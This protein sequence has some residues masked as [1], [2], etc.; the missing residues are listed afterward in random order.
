MKKIV[1]YITE[2]VMSRI[3]H[4]ML[5]E[6]IEHVFPK[7]IKGRMNQIYKEVNKYG[8]SSKKYHDE[9]W[10]AIDDYEF[11]INNLGYDVRIWVEDGGYGDYDEF[12]HMPMSKTYSI[13]I[14]CGDGMDIEGYIKA[15]AAGS[16]QDPFDAYDTCIVLWPARN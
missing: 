1:K 11:V 6:G 4:N 2:D 3:K 10:K 5:N 14:S 9:Y 16:V 15:M 12:T 8:L 13:S 7:S